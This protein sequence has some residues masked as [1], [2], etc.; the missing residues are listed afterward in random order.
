MQ[1]GWAGRF[2]KLLLPSIHCSQSEFTSGMSEP[3]M[4]GVVLSESVEDVKEK[5]K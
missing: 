2:G 4:A 5:R 3:L 1:A